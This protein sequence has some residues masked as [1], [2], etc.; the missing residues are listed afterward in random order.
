MNYA[1][2]KEAVL[3]RLLLVAVMAAGI[4]VTMSRKAARPGLCRAGG[5][6]PQVEAAIHGG[7]TAA[8]ADRVTGGY[9]RDVVPDRGKL[10]QYGVMIEDVQQAVASAL[11]GEAVTTTVEGRERFRCLDAAHVVRDVA[12]TAALSLGKLMIAHTPAENIGSIDR[13][14]TVEID[15][16]LWEWRLAPSAGRGSRA[17]TALG[18]QRRLE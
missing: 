3:G 11:G 4:A 8:H 12:H 16:D 6:R 7:T 17:A 2:V 15:R 5:R 9:F 13:H 18:P 14:R 10:A 1:L